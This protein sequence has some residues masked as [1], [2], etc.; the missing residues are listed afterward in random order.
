MTSENF[1]IHAGRPITVQGF[2]WLAGMDPEIFFFWG[3]VP[4]EEIEIFFKYLNGI[5]VSDKFPFQRFIICL[6]YVNRPPPNC[7]MLKCVIMEFGMQNFVFK[8]VNLL[9]KA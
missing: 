1:F 6:P 3:G 8:K 9:Y 4:K 2:I 7:I 5:L